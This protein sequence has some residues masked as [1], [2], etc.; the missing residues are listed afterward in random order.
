MKC[1]FV[2]RE[3]K[4]VVNKR[5]SGIQ[6]IVDEK[7]CSEEKEFFKM[8]NS[9]Y[10]LVGSAINADGSADEIK[11]SFEHGLFVDKITVYYAG[12]KIGSSQII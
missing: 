3:H 7:V 1:E 4:I 10:E 5:M 12:K 2:Y 6:L 9:D 8:N 11:V